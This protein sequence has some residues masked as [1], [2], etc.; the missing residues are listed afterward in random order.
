MILLLTDGGRKT[1]AVEDIIVGAVK[2]E[3]EMFRKEFNETSL[4][5]LTLSFGRENKYNKF[6]KELTRATVRAS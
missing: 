3:F 6:L 4:K 1:R 2:E 5:L